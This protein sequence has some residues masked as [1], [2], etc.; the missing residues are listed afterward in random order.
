[1]SLLKYTIRRILALIP[2]LLG[3]MFLT[4]WLVRAMP[5]DPWTLMLGDSN[6]TQSKLDFIE[7]QKIKWGEID[8]NGNPV[9]IFTQFLIYI[10]NLLTG[11]WG[12]SIVVDKD[13]PV[14]EVISSRFPKTFEITILAIT[15][16]TLIGIRAGIF[17]AVHRN[18]WSDTII[19]FIA[20]VGVAIPVFWLGMIL[21]YIFAIKLSWVDA[22]LYQSPRYLLFKSDIT[23]L[24]LL[25]SLLKGEF[26]V[27]WDTVSHLILPIF[28]LTFI[29]LAGIT[30]QT[31]SSMLEV[32]E[33]D[34][35]RTARAKGC[36]EKQV[37]YK[38]AWKNAQITTITIVGLSFAGL[39]GGA[40]LTETTFQLNGM[41]MLTIAAINAQ[42]YFLINASVFLMTI[43]F[44]LANL[45]T[46]I[47]Y[48]VVDPR[49]RY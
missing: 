28:C 11:D 38:H 13:R 26:K 27:F 36:T 15:F 14:W 10:K 6:L 8:E 33:L 35:I 9:P 43:I 20:L 45:I 40:V 25:D 18:E 4:F 23:G 31:R 19:R 39:L 49:I 46:D 16:S 1:M 24:R 21:Q 12:V 7:A 42:D 2:I 17:S 5:S 48:G 41:G 37:I 3:V 44:V 47:L 34:Y 30:R 29:S 22:T 32:L